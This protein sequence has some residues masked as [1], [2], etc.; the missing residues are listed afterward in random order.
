M[1]PN[2]AHDVPGSEDFILSNCSKAALANNARDQACK[3][4]SLLRVEAHSDEDADDI[5]EGDTKDNNEDEDN[6][7]SHVHV[8]SKKIS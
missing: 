8:A 6:S 7:D 4:R 2:F 3:I 5:P 1:H